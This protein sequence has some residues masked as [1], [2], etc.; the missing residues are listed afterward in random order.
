MTLAEQ[1]ALAWKLACKAL[2]ADYEAGDDI[3][4]Y[5]KI[6]NRLDELKIIYG[7]PNAAPPAGVLRVGGKRTATK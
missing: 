6:L 7:D 1:Y 4:H 3:D 5:A 2:N